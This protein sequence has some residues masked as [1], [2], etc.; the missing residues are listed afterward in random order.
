MNRGG[1]S[2][3][4]FLGISGLK[5][6]I[7]RTIGI[8]LVPWG[9]H[10]FM[11]YE[12][13]EDLLDALVP[14]FKAG[15]ETDE[16]CFWAV[17][18]PLTVKEATN[19]LRKAV[20]EFDRYLADGSIE[21]V[22]GRQFYLSPK[23][24]DLERVMRTWAEKTDSALARG[25]AGLRV[26]GST[27]WLER[28]H[29]NAFSDYE[30]EVNNFISSWRITVL[31][32]Y[33]MAGSTAAEILDVART[34]QFAIARRNNGWEFVETSELKQAKSEIKKL[35]DELERRVAERTIQLEAVNQALR[36]EIA[37]RRR[38]EEDVRRS[39]DRLRLV[40]DTLPGLV[41]SKLPDGSADF[42]NQRFREYTG[43][44]VEEGLGWGWML[45]AECISSRRSRRG[46]MAGSVCSGTAVRERGTTEASERSL[47]QVPDSCCATARRDGE[48]C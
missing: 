21:I 2:W 45:N 33:P 35:N 19:A 9:T 15:L 24:P 32:T 41:W 20:P 8:P 11:F 38:A 18:A 4:R 7:S 31:C 6:H 22:R 3:W 13:K 37:E 10:F 34:H 26:S 36:K 30:N 27:A 23:A 17:S 47:P 39:E 1:F 5:S 16:L 48:R 43:L 28:R 42:L 14:Y 29:W 44:S 46:R 40:I 25:Y 12:T